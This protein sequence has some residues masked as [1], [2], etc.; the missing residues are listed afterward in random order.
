MPKSNPKSAMDWSGVGPAHDTIGVNVT[1]KTDLLKD[2]EKRF[3]E[4]TGFS[5]ATLNLD[6]AVKLKTD[7]S[8]RHAYA[9]HSHVTADG[10]PV[11][12]L[13]RLSGH[14]GVELVPGSELIEPLVELAV[15]AD[16]SI[17]FFGATDGSLNAAADVLRERYPGVQI[18]LCLAPPMGFDPDGIEADAAINKMVEAGVRLV[19]LALG[20]PKQEK[21]A[22]RAQERLPETGFVSIGAGL[23]FISGAQVRAPLWIRKI[24]AEWL[25]RLAHNPARLARRYGLCI[26]ALPRLTAAAVRARRA[27][28]SHV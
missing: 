6:H 18:N 11:T 17:G 24:A 28:Q 20:A 19:F 23:D 7:A 8:F 14:A 5:I 12:W 27:G 16:I 2:V 4:N 9:A 3:A 26:L 10:K 21:F 25:W 1:S 13:E 15:P 22:A